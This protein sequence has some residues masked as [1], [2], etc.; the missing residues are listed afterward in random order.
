MLQGFMHSPKFANAQRFASL[1]AVLEP[2]KFWHGTSVRE[3]RQRR[4]KCYS[5]A[6]FSEQF[7]WSV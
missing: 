6:E 4:F 2:P 7:W 3:L 5:A 1:N